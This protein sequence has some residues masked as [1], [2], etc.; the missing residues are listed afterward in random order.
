MG[1]G[2]REGVGPGEG[3]TSLVLAISPG[4]RSSCLKGERRPS[5]CGVGDT[6]AEL[7]EVRGLIGG[8]IVLRGEGDRARRSKALNRETPFDRVEWR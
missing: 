8:V 2:W 6:G 3:A 1:G 5:P 7:P 4:G